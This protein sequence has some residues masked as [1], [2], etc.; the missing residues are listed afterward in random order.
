MLAERARSSAQ[1]HP[2]DADDIERHPCPRC[3]A[4]PGTPAPLALAPDTPTADIRIGYARCSTLTHELQSQLNALAKHGIER[5]KVFSEKISTRVRVRPR[6]EAVGPRPRRSPRNSTPGRA[7]A[8]EVTRDRTTRERGFVG[9]P[10]YPFELRVSS[11]Q[12]LPSR[13][14]TGGPESYRGYGV[15]GPRFSSGGTRAGG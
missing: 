14:H 15:N 3:K 13:V 11:L 5:D 10:T 8:V 9:S 12:N 1:S 7:G 6:F 4:D 2:S